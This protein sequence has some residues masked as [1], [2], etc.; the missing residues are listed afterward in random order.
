MYRAGIDGTKWD[1]V[2]ITGQQKV[3]LQGICSWKLQE[4]AGIYLKNISK[5]WEIGFNFSARHHKPSWNYVQVILKYIYFPLDLSNT[6]HP[7]DVLS[8]INIWLTV[9]G[10]G[11][12]MEKEL[13]HLAC[14]HSYSTFTFC[15]EMTKHSFR[16]FQHRLTRNRERMSGKCATLDIW[17]IFFLI[18]HRSQKKT[19]LL[20]VCEVKQTVTPCVTSLR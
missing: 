1:E 3:V 9:K 8:R 14:L 6:S 13:T 2:V 15:P 20:R 4:Y 19:L 16:S 5:M 18:P 10:N 7:E 11:K 12:R 17:G